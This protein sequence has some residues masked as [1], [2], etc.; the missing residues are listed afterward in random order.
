MLVLVPLARSSTVA[1][2][3]TPT[4]IVVSAVSMSEKP[5]RREAEKDFRKVARMLLRHRILLTRLQIESRRFDLHVQAVKDRT[6]A[7]T[8]QVGPI[9]IQMGMK[10]PSQ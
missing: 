8:V 5:A 10:L 7:C 9:K 6:T 4:M 1:R 3:P 2:T